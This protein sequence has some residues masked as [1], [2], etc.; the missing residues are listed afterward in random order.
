MGFYSLRHLFSWFFP[1]TR[2]IKA[3]KEEHKEDDDMNDGLATDDDDRSDNE[4]GE[5]DEFGDEFD[6]TRDI[7]PQ[8]K[9]FRSTDDY[10][11]D[12]DDDFSDDKELQSPIDEVDPFIVFV[13]TTKGKINIYASIRSNEVPK[14]LADSTF[15]LSDLG[16]WSCS[17]C[18]SEM[19][20]DRERKA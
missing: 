4:M 11:D 15:S 6:I 16:K 3:K 20:S 17:T 7:Y 2:N 1:Y 9:A 18:S 12:L 10:G 8:S 5:D 19:S 13:D 14:S